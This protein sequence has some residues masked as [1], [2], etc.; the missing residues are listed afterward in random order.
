[1]PVASRRVL[2]GLRDGTALI[3]VAGVTIS[4]P[5]ALDGALPSIVRRCPFRYTLL[6]I[7]L[8]VALDGPAWV[9]DELDPEPQLPEIFKEAIPLYTSALGSFHRPISSTNETA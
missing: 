7:G 8:G 6:V 9:Q 1:M 4:P 5:S 2:T 3:G